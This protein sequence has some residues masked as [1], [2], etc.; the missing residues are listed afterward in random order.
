[1][2]EFRHIS[3]IQLAGQKECDQIDGD[4]GILIR[5]RIWKSRQCHC[6]K[7]VSIRSSCVGIS[8]QSLKP[9]K[10][11]AQLVSIHGQFERLAIT[12][13]GF[14]TLIRQRHGSDDVTRVIV[15]ADACRGNEF[16]R[17]LLDRWAGVGITEQ[18][19][20]RYDI[21]IVF[22]GDQ[23]PADDVRNRRSSAVTGHH[24]DIILCMDKVF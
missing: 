21:L 6:L 7:C 5:Q 9:L 15:I 2:Q 8:R 3:Q 4:L 19:V 10:D 17:I 14:P 12:G 13:I 22:I 1:M 23:F 24:E 16:F 20:R 11:I 18:I